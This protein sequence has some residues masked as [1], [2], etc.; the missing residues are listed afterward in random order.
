MSVVDGSSSGEKSGSDRGVTPHVIGTWPG[1]TLKSKGN[2]SANDPDGIC[3]GQALLTAQQIAAKFTIGIRTFWRWVASE[4]FPPA[5][6]QMGAKIRRWRCS[7][8]AKWLQR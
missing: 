1:G 5:D 6:V 7:S 2:A 3:D 4:E 8:V